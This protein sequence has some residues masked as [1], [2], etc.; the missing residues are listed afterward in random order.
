MLIFQSINEYLIEIFNMVL[1]YEKTNTL[2]F[3]TQVGTS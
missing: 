3:Q 1:N 2:M